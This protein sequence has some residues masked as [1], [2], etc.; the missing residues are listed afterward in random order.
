M[1]KPMTDQL[2]KYVAL[3]SGLPSGLNKKKL[4]YLLNA[5]VEAVSAEP[6][7]QPHQRLIQFFTGWMLFRI[8]FAEK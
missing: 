8:F 2:E 7:S 6:Y 3:S 1:I 4:C 5:G